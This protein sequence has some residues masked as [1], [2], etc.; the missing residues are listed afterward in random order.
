MPVQEIEQESMYNLQNPILPLKFF[1]DFDW[2]E[3]TTEQIPKKK[4]EESPDVVKSNWYC[5]RH[6]CENHIS[7]LS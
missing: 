6:I 2:N 3:A 7:N 4:T 5:H 1:G